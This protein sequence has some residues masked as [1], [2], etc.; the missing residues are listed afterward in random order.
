MSRINPLYLLALFAI[1]LLLSLTTLQ[2]AKKEQ[3]Q[4]QVSLTTTQKLALQIQAIKSV[5]SKEEQQKG[6]D[7]LLKNPQLKGASLQKEQKTSLWHI[8]SASLS[9]KELEFFLGKI[10]NANYPLKSLKIER[11]DSQK[12]RLDLELQW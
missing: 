4:L 7:A 8:S 12:A 5:Y 9:E 10:L 6:V 2:R 1:M 3:S 11:L